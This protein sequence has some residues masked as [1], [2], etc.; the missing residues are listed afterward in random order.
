MTN[1]HVL[2][3][4]RSNWEYRGLDDRAV[5]EM[6]AELSAHLEDAAAAGRTPRDVVGPDPRAFAAS[7][8]RARR[9]LPRRALR[10]ASLATTV[11]GVL[12]LASHALRWTP[13]LPVE[14]GRVAF[15]GVLAAVTVGWELRR[16]SLGLGRSWLVA[17]LAG[18]PAMALTDWLAGDGP[19]FRLPLWGT[20]LMLL[21]GVPFAV[22][23]VRGRRAAA[24][25]PPTAPPAT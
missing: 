2:A 19:L 6:I 15:F 24:P 12:L 4:C 22:A 18:A 9:S 16:G 7:W 13:T 8:A 10:T 21:P 14:P 1:E 20:L 11:L 25:S 5:A 17:L 23:D 3:V